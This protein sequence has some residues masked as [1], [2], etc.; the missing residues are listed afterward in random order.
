MSNPNS[1]S[2]ID[3]VLSSI[4][5]LVSINERVD[6]PEPV[7]E[8]P[9]EENPVDAWAADADDPAPLPDHPHDETDVVLSSVLETVSL[10]EARIDAAADHDDD[11]EA[12]FSDDHSAGSFDDDDH[13]DPAPMHVDALPDDEDTHI[14]D[15]PPLLHPEADQPASSI[16]DEG[17]LLNPWTQSEDSIS[18]PD[19][20]FKPSASD[21]DALFSHV[22][23]NTDTPIMPY[24]NI[25]SPPT[26]DD[27]PI[28]TPPAS[29]PEPQAPD[30]SAQKPASPGRPVRETTLVPGI[31]AFAPP[32]TT[33]TPKTPAADNASDA[34]LLSPALRIPT[35]A[36]PVANTDDDARLDDDTPYN[37]DTLDAE[38][39]DDE[40]LDDA[41]LDDDLDDDDDTLDDDPLDDD[42][43]DDDAL[44][45]NPFSVAQDTHIDAETTDVPDTP[46]VAETIETTV[47]RSNQDWEPESP[48]DANIPAPEGATTEKA[49]IG[50]AIPAFVRAMQMRGSLNRTPVTEDP[51]PDT[52]EPE[53]VL[54]SELADDTP[55]APSISSGLPPVDFKRHSD[56][57]D[58]ETADDD[59]VDNDD[60]AAAVVHD[61]T[62]RAVYDVHEQIT[63]TVATNLPSAQTA[64]TDMTVAIDEDM[65]RDM[66]TNMV[67]EELQ[68]ALGERITRNVRKLVRRE[69]H[70][71]LTSKDFD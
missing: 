61:L 44:D 3:D 37:D 36:K 54:A 43:L 25:S 28:P 48:E 55:S 1:D 15:D 69:I 6:R 45:I 67:R 46:S 27:W 23:R 47:D 32:T 38:M 42:P 70:R 57:S 50:V 9:V 30:A 58:A 51:T 22:P 66:V 5:R 59:D 14:A 68:G 29:T 26:A 35:P 49:S 60:P 18:D 17:P 10:D 34:L 7:A 16:D 13:D 65:M 39:L 11:D 53:D 62:L 20:P 2:E 41:S 12:P 40:T 56:I 33:D 8:P 52:P 63:E 4:R 21:A 71:A 19:T 31:A 64:P 24:A